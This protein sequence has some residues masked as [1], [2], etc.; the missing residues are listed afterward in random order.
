MS[1]PKKPLFKKVALIGVGLIGSSIAHA[2]RRKHLAEH[3]AGYVP[4]AETRARA[5]AAGFADSLHADLAPTVANADLVIL[6]TPIGAYA[7]LAPLIAFGARLAPHDEK[8]RSR[9]DELGTRA[10]GAL[11]GSDDEM[12]APEQGTVSAERMLTEVARIFREKE[13]TNAEWRERLVSKLLDHE[14]GWSMFFVTPNIPGRKLRHATEATSFGN[15]EEI[16]AVLDCTAL[17][18]AKNCVVFTPSAA[19]SNYAGAHRKIRYEELGNSSIDSSGRYVEKDGSIILE[20]TGS[21]PA[22]RVASLLND[23]GRAVGGEDS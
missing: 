9:L 5:E 6:A 2:A 11:T 18:S 8:F 12:P 19:L 14:A 1:E 22:T 10:D 15:D 3:I 23:I 21:D 17:G 20:T 16:L 7:T 13:G 4:R